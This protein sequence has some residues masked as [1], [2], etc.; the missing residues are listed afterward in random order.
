MLVNISD[1]FTTQDKVSEVQA[2]WEPD[3]FQSN[4][5]GYVVLRK[6]PITLTLTNIGEGEANIEGRINVLLQMQCGR[7]LKDVEKT[8]DISFSYQVKMP[9]VVEENTPHEEFLFMKGYHLD[10]DELVS[11]E[12]LINWPMKVL[13]KDDCK[14]ICALCGK[15]LNDGD[16]GCDTF[17]P[18]PR[19]S[20]IKDIFNA[21]N[22]EV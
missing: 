22:K 20:V 19:M 12:L 21:N 3:V 7:C 13:C 15:D 2:V 14:G 6:E 5:E 8:F 10:V 16:C 18:D 17:V 11:S 9:E 1:V 4:L